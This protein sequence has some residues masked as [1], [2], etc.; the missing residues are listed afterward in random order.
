MKKLSFLLAI[1]MLL[2]CSC[3]SVKPSEIATTEQTVTESTEAPVHEHLFDTVTVTK[4]PCIV[5]G[6]QVATCACGETQ[7]S[8]LP[9]TGKHIHENGVCIGCG[10]KEIPLYAVPSVYDANGDGNT[11]VFYFSP[12]LS[13]RFEN[14]IHVWAGDYDKSLSSATVSTSK[15]ENIVHW[16]V[17]EGTGQY[18]VYHVTV[19]ETGLY[20]M[21]IHIR[22]KDAQE[23]GTKYTI[24][25]GTENEQVFET[26]FGF[27]GIDYEPIRVPVTLTSYMYGVTLNLVEGENTIKIAQSSK[28]PKCQ[29]YRDLYFVKVGEY[30]KHT[31]GIA[32]IT[33]EATCAK[34]GEKISTCTCGLEK[35][36]IIPPTGSHNYVDGVCSVCNRV[37]NGTG[38]VYYDF[39]HDEPGFAG[40]TVEFIPEITDTYTFYWGDENGKLANYTMLYYDDF[41][42]NIPAEITIQS[43]TAIPKG[44]AKLLAIGEKGTTYSYDIPANR[45]L[46]AEELYSFGSLSDTHQG[47]RYGSTSIP[48]NHFI[49][50]AKVLN[51][52]GAIAIGI[53]GD[54]S[55][56]NIESEYILHANAIKEIYKF[57]PDM[58]IFTTSGNHEAKYTGF[59]KDWYL[60]YT[61]DVVDYNSDLELTFFDGNDLDSVVELPDGSVMI[62]LHQQ[63]YDYGKAASRL[64]TDAQLDWLGARL[65]QY[66]DRTVFLY[67]HTFMDEEV[68]DANSSSSEYS[69]PL[70]SSTVEYKRFTE[71]FTN[72]KNVVYFSG[73][74]HWAFDSQ[75]VTP[76]PG[77]TNND[78]NIDDKDGTFATMVHIPA[79]STPRVLTGSGSGRSEGYIVHVY[80]DY[81]IFEGYD[82]V[83]EQTFAYATYIIQK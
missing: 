18:I 35:I 2:L 42:A 76:K 33:K 22:L 78:K 23:R 74:S 47:T 40:G 56:D 51:K 1:L 77:K 41:S 66:K 10:Q 32:T 71:Y 4:T 67:F 72:Y 24:N 29:H 6:E 28:S 31:F 63:Y 15:V 60:Q 59:S 65:E 73:H 46:N 30:H 16:F 64:L 19:P 39:L 11:D 58:P 14:A 52:K 79:C 75:F 54:F 69:L 17:T 27:D 55:Y 38:I 45:L 43:F 12:Q 81:V 8:P 34:E 25:E 48:Y 20:E 68:G 37:D 53:C 49:N 21:A 70:I 13:D 36:F 9:A 50:A 82:F 83:G 26:S 62:Y 7:V 5:A 44:A 57:A 80:E 3:S 61:R